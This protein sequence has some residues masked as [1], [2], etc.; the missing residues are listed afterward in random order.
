M[1]SMVEK[2]CYATSPIRLLVIVILCAY[3]YVYMLISHSKSIDIKQM[4]CE[5]TGENI[6]YNKRM[7]KLIT[8][9]FFQFSL[10]FNLF[11][12]N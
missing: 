3:I 12:K 2:Y 10:S 9:T 6:V 11:E 7:K 1:Y 4:K 8:K 5:D